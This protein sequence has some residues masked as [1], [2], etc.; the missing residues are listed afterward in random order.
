MNGVS[1]AGQPPDDDDYEGSEL[2][3]CH[4]DI[5]GIGHNFDEHRQCLCEPV[6][7][8]RAETER[9]DFKERLRAATRRDH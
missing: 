6:L 1:E 4:R 9:P 5:P 7:F 2:V 8:T 3:W